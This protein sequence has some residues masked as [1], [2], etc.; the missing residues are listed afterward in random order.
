MFSNECYP[1]TNPASLYLYYTKCMK[2][3]EISGVNLETVIES[4]E[5][6]DNRSKDNSTLLPSSLGM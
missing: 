4:G 3:V 2:C 5:E 6:Q 1:Q